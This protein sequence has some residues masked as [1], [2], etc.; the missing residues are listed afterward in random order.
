MLTMHKIINGPNNKDDNNFENVN[1]YSTMLLFQE[2]K[3]RNARE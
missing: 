3:N 2:K 1:Y